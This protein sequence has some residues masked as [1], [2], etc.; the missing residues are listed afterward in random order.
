MLGSLEGEFGQMRIFRPNRDVRFSRDKSPYRLEV[1]ATSEARAVGGIGYYVEV[2]ATRMIAGFRAMALARDQ[3]ERFRAAIV[4]VHSGRQ[5]EDMHREL[6]AAEVPLSPG[7][8]QPLKNVPRGYPS[9][10]PL[11]GFLRWK[12]VAVVAQYDKAGWMH[13]ADAEVQVRSLWRAETPL[14][15]WLGTHV[16]GSE[17]P[18]T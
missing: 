7:A 11:S 18:A 14:R 12:G 16:G 15:A 17:I 13:T 8:T 4:S 6:A 1:A 3:L 5:F 2:S 10:H 9:D